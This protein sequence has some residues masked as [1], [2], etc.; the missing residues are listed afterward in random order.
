MGAQDR[1]GSAEG[2]RLLVGRYELGERLGRGGMGTVWRARDRM[3]DREVAVKELT[4]SHLPEEE[5]EI[6]HAR[7]KREA[8]AAARIKHPGVITVHDVLEQDGRPWIVMELV[9]GR[10]LA[11]VISQDGT[12]PPRAAAEVGGQVLAALHRGHQLGVLHRDVKPANVLLEHGTGR[13]VLLDFGIA[14]YEGSAELTRPGD[15]VGSPDYLAP[16]RAQGERPGPASDLWGLGATLYAAVEGDSPFRR[17]SP[18]TTLAAV[19]GDPLPEPRRAGPLG[20]VLAALMAKDPD[21]R[22]SA[23]EAARMLAEVQA[24]HTVGLKPVAPVRMPTQSVPVVD[25]AGQQ[26]EA[27]EDRAE[28][29]SETGDEAGAASAEGAEAV[30]VPRA[31]AASDPTASDRAASEWVASDRAEEPP[32]EPSPGTGPARESDEGAPTGP[33]TPVS[34]TDAPARGPARRR[35]VLRVLAI[36]VGLAVLAAGALYLVQRQRAADPGRS[37]PTLAP[38]SVGPQPTAPVDGTPAP[39]GY[40]WVD[41]P[42]GFRFPLPVT[43]PAW[44]RSSTPDN[45]IYYSPDNKGHYLQFAVT[46]GQSVRPLEHMRQME[47]TVSKSLKEYKQHRLTGVAVNGHEAAVWEFSYLAKEGGRR[48]AIEAEFIDEDGTSYAIYSSSFDRG[49]EWNEAEQRFNAVLHYF[50]PTR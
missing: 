12:L 3:L 35:T 39:S 28:D 43:V 34:Y 40:Q 11:D 17:T 14:T 33:V 45:Q 25:R 29:R 6:L 20:P 46:V 24:G 21:E 8:A 50:T 36:V 27:S 37:A 42:A 19:V 23:D 47:S 10:S 13:A 26:E 15:L 5:V 31:R 44:Q 1:P 41:D 22:P 32:T 38:G 4:V 48:R 9:D 30:T 16:E 2:E 18:L 7:M 49:N